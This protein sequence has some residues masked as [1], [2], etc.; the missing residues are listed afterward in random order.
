MPRKLSRMRRLLTTGGIAVAALAAAPAAAS[1]HDC[2]YGPTTKAFAQF[3]D[4]ADYY[5]TPGGSF[6]ELTWRSSRQPELVDG[7]NPFALAGGVRSLHL[8]DGQ[9]V[10]SPQ[11]CVSRDTPHLRFMARSH[12]GGQLDVEVRVWVGGR[13]TD[14]SSGSV[15]PGAHRAWAPSRN[16][17]LKT[18]SIPRGQTG[19]VT[20]S[21]RSQGDWLLD[22]VFVDPYRR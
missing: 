3:G 5:L 11:L 21:F 2:E 19:L 13:V 6:D 15:S 1:A 7:V 22:D 12:R 9:S 18:S 17:D 14:S 20:V 10:T 4:L 16:I 8:E